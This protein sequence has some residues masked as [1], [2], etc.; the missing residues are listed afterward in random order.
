M[1]DRPEETAR[2]AAAEP[3]TNTERLLER[4]TTASLVAVL[5]ALGWMV[6]VSRRAGVLRLPSEKAEVI[7]V[8][9]LLALT[10]GL[11]AVLA[12]VH[13]RRRRL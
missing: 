1:T 8:A 7:L 3:K 4:A 6:V 10:L 9:G 5:A 11:V 13:T 2:G 12:L